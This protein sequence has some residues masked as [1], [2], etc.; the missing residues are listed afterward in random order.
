MAAAPAVGPETATI[1]R[2]RMSKEQEDWSAAAAAGVR[3][4]ARSTI[5]DDVRTGRPRPAGFTK[6]ANLRVFLLGV[7]GP[8]Q[9]RC[10][11]CT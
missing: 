3:G 1:E 7:I 4:R 6:F 8:L 2:G 9:P 5:D 10:H 11:H